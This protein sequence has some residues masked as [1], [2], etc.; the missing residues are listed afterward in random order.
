M[1]PNYNKIGARFF[2]FFRMDI[3]RLRSKFRNIDIDVPSSFIQKMNRIDLVR[4]LVI[5]ELG[6]KAVE[7]YEQY[8]R[9]CDEGRAFIEYGVTPRKHSKRSAAAKKR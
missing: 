8:V 9:R 7:A 6:K 2:Y 3:K 5:N 1:T 4:L